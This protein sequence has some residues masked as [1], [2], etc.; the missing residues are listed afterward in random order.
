[1]NANYE[2]CIV[3]HSP[4]LDFAESNL[5]FTIAKHHCPAPIQVGKQQMVILPFWPKTQIL[6]RKP[7]HCLT[8]FKF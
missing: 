5:Q 2:T 7:H 8:N 3:N 4:N 1:M 6:E